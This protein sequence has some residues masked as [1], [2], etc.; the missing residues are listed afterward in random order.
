MKNYLLFSTIVLLVMIS[1]KVNAQ[2][3]YPR[4]PSEAK[5]ISTDIKNFIDAYNSLSQDKDSISIFQEMYFDNASPGM[6]EYLT[7][8]SFNAEDLIREMRMHPEKYSGVEKFYD[9]LSEFETDYLKE[10][11]AYKSV[12]PNAMFPPVYLIV[13]NYTGIAQASKLGQLV[14]IEKAT[15]E[16]DKLLTLMIH[17]LTHF[18]QAMNMGIEK[19]TGVY[20]KQDNMLDLI[21][22]EGCAEFVTYKLVRKNE[23][24][25]SRLKKYEENEAELWKKFMSD[26]KEQQSAYWLSVTPENSENGNTILLGYA[27]GYKIIEAYYN[28]VGN[29]EQA[30]D[31]ILNLKDALVILENSNYNPIQ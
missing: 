2:P 31:D 22:R 16:P 12:M 10:L 4:V 1:V 14:T 28:H 20:A 29:N 23:D 27:V 6:K 26:L 11:E 21:L 3:N 30:L 8:H 25:F 18:Q 19:Y 5:I 17:E 15:E 9:R 7:K 24:Q 13:G